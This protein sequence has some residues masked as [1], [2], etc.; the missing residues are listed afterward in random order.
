MKNAFFTV[1][2]I[3]IIIAGF[4][5]WRSASVVA[6]P[7]Q[8]LADNAK[9]DN[10]RS[11]P[12]Q[13]ATFDRQKFSLSNPAS[14]W[15]VVNKR[16]P[17][18]PKDYAPK[19]LIGVGNGQE[20]R[21]EAAT[22]LKKMIAAANTLGYT[23]TPASGYRSYAMQVKAYDSEVAAYGKATADSESARPGYSE[24]QTGWA[25][26]LA[27]DG[28]SVS[29]CFGSTPGGKWATANAYKYGFI[30]RYPE[31]LASITGYRHETWHFRYVGIS[32]AT[33]MQKDGVKTLEQFFH[34]PAAPDYR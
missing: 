21:A 13:S 10:S 30:L 32:L 31:G 24:H 34:L 7:N 23:L 25:I 3:I 27:S 11:Q 26:D 22:A 6:P 20:M 1:V 12:S 15:V 16:R 18:E 4:L 2:I 5:I 8:T 19:D 29:D 17:L 33:E 9:T 28:C 14:L